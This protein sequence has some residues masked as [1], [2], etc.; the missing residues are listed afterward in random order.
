M[1]T[2]I[3]PILILG[4][5]INGSA[6]ARELALNG[7]PVYLV[8]R[9]DVASG[10]TAYSSRLIHG[11]L[12]YLEFGEFD[13]VR[14]SLEER[15]RWLR[16]APH[17]VKPLRLFIPVGRFFGGLLSSALRFVHWDRGAGKT[18]TRGL[19]AIV[20][21]L[22]LYDSYAA[23]PN[24]EGF[25]VC[26]TE[27]VGKPRVARS[28]YRW[29]CAYTDGQISYPER[30]TLALVQ[31]AR[32]A[33]EENG[34]EFRLFTYHCASLHGRTVRLEPLANL[35]GPTVTLEP[36]IVVNATGA[37]VDETLR[38]LQ[39]S[40]KRLL[41]GTKGSH[42]IS[43]H[44]GFRDALGGR[45]IYAEAQDGRPVFIVPFVDGT[46]VGTTDE[47]FGGDPGEAIATERELLYLLDAVN[48][49]MPGVNLTRDDIDM[50]YSGVRPLPRSDSTSTAGIT[51]RHFLHEHPG[52]PVPM[53]SVIGGKLTTCRSL[54]EEAT[55]TLLAR[56]GMKPK[57]NSRDRVLPG[58][59]NYPRSAE[60][61]TS[62]HDRIAGRFGLSLLQVQR[63]WS[64]LGSRTET[65][66]ASIE[67]LSSVN[68]PGT[69]IPEQFAR[70]SI[71]QEDVQKLDDLV[72]RRLMLVYHPRLLPVCLRRLAELLVDSGKL[73]SER[74]EETVQH[75]IDRLESR[76]GKRILPAFEND[77]VPETATG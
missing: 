5:G 53:F 26:R 54:A 45:G 49:L 70:W 58:G 39:V 44:S 34:S 36:S 1:S 17:Y 64:L 38:Q 10:T 55:A 40:E 66:L 68:L 8:D 72:E 75:T 52:T 31:D 21:G 32:R 46:L 50:H 19:M 57:T 35:G 23:D 29:L 30:F 27:E 59:G 61:L 62:E 6:L 73:D 37:W 69:D 18:R 51:R 22:K 77:L 41:G 33:A 76:F 20:A 3:Q 9:A 24:L 13:L 4:A 42:F 12:R 7:V 15:T 28:K 14:E 67:G 11:G 48:H 47:R 56:L 63:I 65:V 25:R 74:L 2:A 60:Q 43:S 71:L 16:L